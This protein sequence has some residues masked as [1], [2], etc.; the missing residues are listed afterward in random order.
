MGIPTRL[1]N[2]IYAGKSLQED[3]KL[4]DYDI[5]PNLTIILNMR[6]LGGF[7]GSSS[8]GQTSFQDAVKGKAKQ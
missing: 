7:L 6:L 1:Q 8:K 5:G 2:L 3:S 4:Q